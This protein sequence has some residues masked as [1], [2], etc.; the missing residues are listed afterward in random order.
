MGEIILGTGI[1]LVACNRIQDSMERFGSR[2]LNRIFIQTEL[3]YCLKQKYP[4][5]HLAARFAAKE[6]VSKAFGTGIGGHLGWKDMEVHR[7]KSGEPQLRLHNKGVTL[8]ENKN[9]I[10][11]LISLTHTKEYGAATAI[12]IGNE[13][14]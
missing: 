2:F 10:R 13:D 5:C 1:D 3:D 8:L 11:V 14:C 7:L 9:G 12:L 4:E 6:A